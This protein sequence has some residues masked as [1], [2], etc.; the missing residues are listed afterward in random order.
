MINGMPMPNTVPAVAVYATPG[1][2]C[3]SYQFKS[4]PVA[5]WGPDGT[6]LV[7]VPGHVRLVSVENQGEID[8]RCL[9]VHPVPA[10]GQEPDYSDL[11]WG[12]P[13]GSA[14]F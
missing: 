14:P 7:V 4:Y 3:G 2:E 6:A 1:E 9:G 12:E 10:W 8:G 13:V 5:A 11:Y